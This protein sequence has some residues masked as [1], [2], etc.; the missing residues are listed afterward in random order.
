MC[1][2]LP[3]R[4]AVCKGVC[5]YLR[6]WQSMCAAQMTITGPGCGPGVA[7]ALDGAWMEPYTLPYTQVWS[8]RGNATVVGA[9]KDAAWP[10]VAEG[11]GDGWGN[12]TLAFQ[13]K[14]TCAKG[15]WK[16]MGISGCVDQVV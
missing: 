16:L 13:L 10:C 2:G 5:V 6:S 3:I 8:A 4:P 9:G 11:G 15:I 7:V 1:E 12:Y 14:G